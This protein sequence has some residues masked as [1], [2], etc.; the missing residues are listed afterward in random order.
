MRNARSV[1]LGHKSL[2][3]LAATYVSR[4]AVFLF[5]SGSMSIP[6]KTTYKITN[7]HSYN[8]AL[9]QCCSLAVW[10]DPSMQWEA[11]PFG[12]RGRR[13]SYRDAAFQVCLALQ[14]PQK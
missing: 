4:V 3:T 8:Q 7:R 10:V 6:P 5:V 9:K 11:V 12:L 1:S 2:P 13:Q 14:R